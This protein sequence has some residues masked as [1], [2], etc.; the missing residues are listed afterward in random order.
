MGRVS[1]CPA[2]GVPQK[3]RQPWRRPGC[4]PRAQLVPEPSAWLLTW[5]FADSDR[6]AWSDGIDLDERWVR[7]ARSECLDWILVWDDRHR[8]RVLTAYLAHYNTS[9]PQR[10]LGLDISVPTATVDHGPVV[11]GQDVERIDVLGGLIHE[12]GRAA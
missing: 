7:T 10:G 5:G 1:A 6:L 11:A 12:N 4:A 3:R 9:R 2:A 8:N